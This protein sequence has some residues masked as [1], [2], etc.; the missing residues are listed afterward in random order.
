MPA[1]L[2]LP[3]PAL[4]DK[5]FTQLRASPHGFNVIADFFSRGILNVN[6][7]QSESN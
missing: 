3:M 6:N 7:Q 5:F 1:L 2:R 4:Q